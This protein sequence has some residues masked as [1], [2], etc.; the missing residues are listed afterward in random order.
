MH[1][2]DGRGL[3]NKNCKVT[4]ITEKP[5]KPKSNW[6]VSGLYFYDNDAIKIAENLKPSDRFVNRNMP[7][8]V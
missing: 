2:V 4:S 7:E 5:K 8:E 6:A 3:F 1:G